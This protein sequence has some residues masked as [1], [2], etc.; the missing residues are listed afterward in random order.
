MVKEVN[1][2]PGSVAATGDAGHG[3]RGTPFGGSVAPTAQIQGHIGVLRSQNDCSGS[4]LG[5][6]VLVYRL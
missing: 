5:I 3:V 2:I 1:E 4:R 6:V